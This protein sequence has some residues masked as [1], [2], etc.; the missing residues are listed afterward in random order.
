[1]I[2]I[3][4]EPLKNP[5]EQPKKLLAYNISN[6][7]EFERFI[8]ACILVSTLLISMEYYRMDE[9]YYDRLRFTS[10][11]LTGVYNL[12]AVI[13]IVAYDT[14]Y[15]SVMWNRFD[16]FIVIVAD[17]SLLVDLFAGDSSSELFKILN[18]I[19]ALRIM[20]IFRLVRVSRNLSILVDSLIVILPSIANVGSL[21]MLLFFIFSVIGMNMFATVI[22][23]EELNENMNFQNFSMALI[24]LL[25]CSTGENWNDIMRELAI[26]ESKPI[27]TADGPEYCVTEQS[28]AERNAVGP[29]ECG[30]KEAY[31]YFGVFIVVIQMMMLNLFI[32]VVLEGFSSTNKEHTGVVTS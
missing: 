8:S 12:E 20:R 13:K 21:I 22:Y 27:E 10:S 9:T 5:P 24:I 2:R 15:F 4:I 23:Q 14:S 29:K 16:F 1:M 25:R 32:A 26:E 11:I 6:S 3:V 17:L 18:L 31:I 19:K 7:K 28:Y 30:G